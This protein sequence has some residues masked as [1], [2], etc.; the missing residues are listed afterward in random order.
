VEG[1]PI[2]VSPR[3]DRLGARCSVRG[4]RQTSRQ[5][6]AGTWDFGTGQREKLSRS[7]TRVSVRRVTQGAVKGMLYCKEKRETV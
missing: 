7:Q 2:T 3:R 5:T 1:E 4:R 6:W